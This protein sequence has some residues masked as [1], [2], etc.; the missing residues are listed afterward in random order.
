MQSQIAQ[1][2]EAKEQQCDSDSMDFEDSQKING[3]SERLMDCESS[4]ANKFKNIYMPST[5]FNIASNVVPPAPP[6]PP[7]LMARLPENDAD[8]LS[9]MLM[10]WYIS[11]FHTGKSKLLI[12]WYN[13]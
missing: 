5:S 4:E 8:A 6:L 11:G 1:E 2:K 10:S 7:Q 12:N 13:V 9:S 3:F